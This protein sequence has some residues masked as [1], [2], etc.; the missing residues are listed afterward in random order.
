MTK[1]GYQSP[2]Y[3]ED[4]VVMAKSRNLDSTTRIQR[5]RKIVI[6]SSVIAGVILLALVLGLGLGL[7]LKKDKAA[8]TYPSENY[9][10]VEQYQGTD[11]FNKFDYWSAADP[12]E[13]FVI[14]QLRANSV[15]E[16]Y[17]YASESAA[18]I[19][20]DTNSTPTGVNSV[21]I[22]S[23]LNYTQGLFVADIA[24]MPVGCGVWPAFWLSD[25]DN[26]PDNGEIDILEGVNANTHN[27]ATLHS[28]ASCT[29]K[30]V[31]RNETG[32][33]LTK[34]CNSGTGTANSGCGVNDTTHGTL[35]YGTG[36]NDNGG[37][38][39]AMDWR[40]NGIRVW[41]FPRTALPADLQVLSDDPTST[42]VPTMADWGTATANF[43]GTHCDIDSHFKNHKIIFD[44]TFCGTW[45]GAGST[46]NASSCYDA[47]TAP[48]CEKYMLASPADLQTAY[49]EVRSLN[50]YQYDSGSNTVVGSEFASTTTSSAIAAPTSGR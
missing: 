35:S 41:F 37:G 2:V 46:W 10:L 50:V 38:I 9:A 49:W 42:A 6:V 29:M 40:S 45:A 11:F 21:R 34:N 7:G 1:Q 39:Y 5:R 33:V 48:T 47:T 27:Q 19:R 32:T 31:K 3:T 24:H 14:Y 12:T 26:W 17:T 28:S 43:P 8:P 22:Q 44:T 20:S 15:Y 18:I 23:T 4:D 30:G 36:F 25:T 13:G 16:N